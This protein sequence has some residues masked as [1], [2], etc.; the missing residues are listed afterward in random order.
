MGG[1]ECAVSGYLWDKL[2][3]E[4]ENMV[5]F[6]THAVQRGSKSAYCPLRQL[7]FTLR[8]RGR[9]VRADTSIVYVQD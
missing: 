8:V 1:P 6:L 7:P 4:N 3:T 2:A 5:E 9:M